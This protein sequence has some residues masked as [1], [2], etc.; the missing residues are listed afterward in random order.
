MVLSIKEKDFIKAAIISNTP[1]YKIMLKH[2][3]PNIFFSVIIY[4]GTNISIIVM[5]VASLSFLG[6]GAQPPLSEWGSMLNDA[7]AAAWYWYGLCH[8]RTG[9]FYEAQ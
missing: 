5:Q 7:K 9:Q 4:A 2:I 8:E 6:L 3:L 1:K